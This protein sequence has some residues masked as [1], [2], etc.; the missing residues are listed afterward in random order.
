MSDFCLCEVDK[1]RKI[2][3]P[4]YNVAEPRDGALSPSLS[5]VFLSEWTSC[6]AGLAQ[7]WEANWQSSLHCLTLALLLAGAE[8]FSLRLWGLQT[9]PPPNLENYAISRQAVNGIR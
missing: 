5:L 6:S 7:I 2:Y 3:A 9:P 8:R 1:R 4:N